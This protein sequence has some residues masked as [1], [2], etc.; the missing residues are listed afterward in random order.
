MLKVKVKLMQI[1]IANFSQTVSDRANIAIANKH[2]LVYDH[3]ISTSTFDT[4]PF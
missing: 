1:S 2:K 4:G 3:S